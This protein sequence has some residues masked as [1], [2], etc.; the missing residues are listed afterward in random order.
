MRGWGYADKAVEAAT[1]L[2][3]QMLRWAWRR[4]RDYRL[5]AASF[6]KAR[7]EPQPCFTSE[8]VDA[9]IEAAENEEKLVCGLMGYAGP[10]I[11]EVEQLRWDDLH[12]SGSRFTMIHVRRGGSCG[13]TKDEEDRFVPVHPTIAAL[14]EAPAKKTLRLTAI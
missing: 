1:V 2:A 14:L 13:R 10:W 12:V 9:W 5:T 11:R 4:L 3:K 7:A 8:Q 6:H